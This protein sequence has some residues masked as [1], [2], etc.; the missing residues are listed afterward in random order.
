MFGKE[1]GGEGRERKRREDG[2][3]KR[4]RKTGGRADGCIFQQSRSKCDYFPK[5]VNRTVST[6]LSLS[7]NR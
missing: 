3:E 7:G 6:V 5:I 2:N 1:R 4:N